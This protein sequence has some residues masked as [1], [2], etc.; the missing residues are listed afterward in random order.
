MHCAAVVFNQAYICVWKRDSSSSSSSMGFS[1][2][3]QGSSCLIASACLDAAPCHRQ[4][5]GH[6][7]DVHHP[8][9]PP[10]AHHSE[11]APNDRR[12][13]TRDTRLDTPQLT[14]PHIIHLSCLYLSHTSGSW[15]HSADAVRDRT[16]C[17]V[18]ISCLYMMHHVKTCCTVL[19]NLG[20]RHVLLTPNRC[21][22]AVVQDGAS[23]SP[24][25]CRSLVW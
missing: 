24:T 18:C 3:A 17:H 9:L 21:Q 23:P 14:R 20:S 16:W 13:T 4:L 25:T 7:S 6:S 12:V 5:A 15:N 10:P 11:P 22:Q 8:M 19:D 1:S 2:L